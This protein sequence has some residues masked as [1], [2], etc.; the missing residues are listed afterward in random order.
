MHAAVTDVRLRLLL[1]GSPNPL[2]VL[3]SGSKIGPETVEII[4]IIIV[5]YLGVINI[6]LESYGSYK[7]DDA[8]HYLVSSWVIHGCEY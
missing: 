5:I 8:R 2:S 1:W 4:G 7:M 3:P 6:I